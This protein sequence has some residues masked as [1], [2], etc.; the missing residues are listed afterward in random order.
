MIPLDKNNTST[1]I[2]S[3]QATAQPRFSTSS[4]KSKVIE[5]LAE[6]Q[7]IHLEKDIDQRINAILCKSSP[8]FMLTYQTFEEIKKEVL[9]TIPSN[10]PDATEISENIDTVFNR[11]FAAVKWENTLDRNNVEKFLDLYR[12]FVIKNDNEGENSCF[13]KNEWILDENHVF[14]LTNFHNKQFDYR[15]L[16]VSLQLHEI[17]EIYQ[18]R[19]VIQLR[20]IDKS[21]TTLIIGCGNGRLSNCGGLAHAFKSNYYL[22]DGYDG[23]Y[24]L[25]H[26]HPEAVTID[27]SLAANPTIVA[28]FGNQQV[29]QI[30]EGQKFDKIIF[31]GYF[32]S[33]E[34]KFRK[35]DLFHLLNKNG[36]IFSCTNSTR[37]PQPIDCWDKAHINNE[38]HPFFQPFFDGD[39]KECVLD[40]YGDPYYP[41]DII[42]MYN[43]MYDEECC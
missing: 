24:S 3:A 27:P 35:F 25:N 13:F 43:E 22:K 40:V 37:G 41:K 26:L 42:T 18:T 2:G 8:N 11:I 33:S 4:F 16:E 23:K 7:T 15:N 34:Q 39:G 36:Q 28:F 20:P 21:A 14:D 31:E 1:G 17:Q 29:S 9:A 19:G 30:F 10:H 38:P 12:E 32:T 6:T 5:V